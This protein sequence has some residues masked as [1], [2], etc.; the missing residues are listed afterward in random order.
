M[1]YNEIMASVQ[2]LKNEVIKKIREMAPNGHIFKTGEV[3]LEGDTEEPSLQCTGISF[4]DGELVLHTISGYEEDVYT[5]E[6]VFLFSIESFAGVVKQLEVE[7]QPI[8]LRKIYRKV[9]DEHCKV[10]VFVDGKGYRVEA[11]C[12]WLTITRD[13]EHINVDG[14]QYDLAMKILEELE[15]N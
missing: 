6:D 4:L 12:G 2:E 3:F 5:D 10:T 14:I 11:S 1:N 15:A 8:I 7:L 9:A 13:G